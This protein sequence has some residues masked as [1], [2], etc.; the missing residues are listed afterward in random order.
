MTTHS[1]P[2][3]VSLFT[4]CS[5][6]IALL[7]IRERGSLSLSSPLLSLPLPSLPSLSHP[8]HHYPAQ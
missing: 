3:P 6:S 8:S 4:D 1:L 7:S 2:L 5:P